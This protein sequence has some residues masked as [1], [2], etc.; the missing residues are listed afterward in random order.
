MQAARWIVAHYLNP[1]LWQGKNF[2]APATET[3]KKLAEIWSGILIVEKDVIGSYANFFDL[4][5]H[6]LSATILAGK[7]HKAF[8][9]KIPLP[10][11]FTNPE[12]HRLAATSKMPNMKSMRPSVLP[13][14]RHS[15]IIIRP[16]ENVFFKADG[17]ERH[18]LQHTRD[19]VAGQSN[20]A[21][22]PGE[23]I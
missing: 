23:S 7:I 5:G 6:S 20:R 10:E 18:R 9:V 12:L 19:H 11:I 22:T 8:N 15:M 17:C 2:V 4:G 13:L 14:K 21:R 1:G 16:K 3:E